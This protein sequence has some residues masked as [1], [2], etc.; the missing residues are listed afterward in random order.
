MSTKLGNYL[1][2]LICILKHSNT[3]TGEKGVVSYDLSDKKK[4]LLVHAW[5]STSSGV[6]Q[7][8]VYDLHFV[9]HISF[10]FEFHDPANQILHNSISGR[11]D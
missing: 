11:S 4:S 2:N 8:H 1:D 7:T 10:S 6:E 5:E 3:F 9:G